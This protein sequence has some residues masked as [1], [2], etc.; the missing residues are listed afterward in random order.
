MKKKRTVCLCVQEDILGPVKWMLRESNRDFNITTFREVTSLSKIANEDHWDLLVLDASALQEP[1]LSE[2]S[3]L[4]SI[5]PKLATI[6][7]VPQK[8][9]QKDL[10]EIISKKI[11]QGLVLRPF[12]EEVITHYLTHLRLTTGQIAAEGAARGS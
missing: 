7:I 6:L 8:S 3:K 2:L 4:R 9:C 5:K 1:M 12:T 10:M 11:V